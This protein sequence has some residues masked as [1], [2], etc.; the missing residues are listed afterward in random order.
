[1]VFYVFVWNSFQS[2]I[3]LWFFFFLSRGGFLSVWYYWYDPTARSYCNTL[4]LQRSTVVAPLLLAFGFW[5]LWTCGEGML[6]C[7]HDLSWSESESDKACSQNPISSMVLPKWTISLPHMATI[8]LMSK[9][10]FQMPLLKLLRWIQAKQAL[11]H[12]IDRPQWQSF[13][14]DQLGAIFIM[15]SLCKW[16]GFK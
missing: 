12:V 13:E 16:I 14:C 4:H 5:V 11:A 6:W 10:D 1:M 2:Q 9:I 3:L 8:F 7:R 15:L